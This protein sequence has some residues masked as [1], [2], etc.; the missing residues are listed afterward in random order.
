MDF[1]LRGPVPWQNADVGRAGTVHVGGT[2]PEMAAAEAAVA[3]GRHADRPM[4]LVSDPT[5]VDPSR[6]V[7]ELRPL[8][9]YAHVPAARRSTSRR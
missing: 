1:V 9:T 2:R 3:A 7:G 5:V 6:R 4:V 8:W